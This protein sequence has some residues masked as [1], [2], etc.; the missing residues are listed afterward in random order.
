M[1][2][3]RELL[4][5]LG[6]VAFASAAPGA[7]GCG[8]SDPPPPQTSFFDSQERAALAAIADAVIPPDDT[9]GGADLGVVGYIETL[10]TALDGPDV[11]RIWAGGPYSGR[12]PFAD[13]SRPQN[14]FP[15]FL[16][17]DRIN[18]ISWKR[19]V[20]ELK[21]QVKDGLKEAIAALP[22][23]VASLTQPQIV[24]WFR[25]LGA[26]FRDLMI[27]LV[28]QGAFAAPEYGG[29]VALGGWKLC[30]YEGD[31]QPLGYSIFD[32]KLQAYRERSD[33]PMST[34][35]PGPDPLPLDAEVRGILDEL[36]G[37]LGGK[38]AP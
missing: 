4:V 30:H 38:I 3:R 17:L 37:A 33:A 5:W 11:P 10:L 32:E 28:C 19:R 25:G 20:D 14:E 23:P 29:N 2:S 24:D 15:S 16:E 35:N 13:G 7:I 22:A 12:L 27:D 9:P 1:V 8:F 26:G 31:V 21:A 6:S 18:A 34:A 36:V